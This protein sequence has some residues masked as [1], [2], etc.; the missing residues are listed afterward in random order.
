MLKT[1][2]KFLAVAACLGSAATASAKMGDGGTYYYTCVS[3]TVYYSGYI[4]EWQR[5]DAEAAC[6]REGGHY[7]DSY[8]GG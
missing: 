8:V 5:H 3:S 6:S 4:G 7:T 2:C 1:F